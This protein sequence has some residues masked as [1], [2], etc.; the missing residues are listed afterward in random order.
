MQRLQAAEV[1]LDWVGP[2]AR[3][4]R[5][6]A[7]VDGRHAVVLRSV[8]FAMP[9]IL[10]VVAPLIFLSGIEGRLLRPLGAPT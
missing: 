10:L 1:E 3:S 2:V 9:V 6:S 8:V 7:A 5:S 4:G